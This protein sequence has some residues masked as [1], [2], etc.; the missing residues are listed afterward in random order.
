M[1]T[2]G[3]GMAPFLLINGTL[4]EPQ[5]DDVAIIGENRIILGGMGLVDALEAMMFLFYVCNL[6]YPKE[7]TNTFILVQ[8]MVMKVYDTQKVPTKVLV[9]MSDLSKM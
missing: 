1:K 3:T 2:T 5:P 9:L 8:R 7:C 4:E 6:Q